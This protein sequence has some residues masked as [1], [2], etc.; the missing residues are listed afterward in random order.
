[1]PEGDARSARTKL[2]EPA[3][4][5]HEAPSLAG[6]F[7]VLIEDDPQSREAMALQ[8]RQWGCHVAAAAS[9]SELL[10]D[11][12]G[13]LRGPDAI[14]SD[15]RLQAMPAGLQAVAQLRE[16][17]NEP[18]PAMIVTGEAGAEDLILLQESGLPILFK[19][20]SPADLRR[21][22]AALLSSNRR[23]TLTTSAAIG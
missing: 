12:T 14:I 16:A 10:N 5:D 18:V 17:L 20:V 11:L 9:A 7:I 1:M 15:Y 19:P 3:I 6:A 2:E 13:H 8:L 21:E 4:C 23:S 22:L